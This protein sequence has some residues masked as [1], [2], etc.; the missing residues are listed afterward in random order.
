MGG[1][2]KNRSINWPLIFIL[3][4]GVLVRTQGL[5]N[6]LLDD[7]G[8]RQADTASMAYHMLGRLTA[9]PQ[10]WFPILNY[11]G[12]VPQK[13]ELEFPFLPYIIAW[14]WTL[15]GQSDLWGRIWAIVFSMLTVWGIFV[16]GQ[17]KFSSRAGLWAAGIYAFVP[18]TAYYGRVVMPEPVAQA[19]SIWALNAVV[20]W[21]EKPGRLRLAGAGLVMAFA[22]LA[23]L[24]QLMI[25]PVGIMLGFWP[26][27]GEEKRI[28]IYSLF[29]LLPPGLYYSWVHKG[30][31]SQASQFV[32]GILSGQVVEGTGLLSQKLIEN[33]LREVGL[34]VSLLA[35]AGIIRFLMV[36]INKQ[37]IIYD[38]NSVNIQKDR[39]TIYSLFLWCIISLSYVAFI[40]SRIA[41]DYY[42]VPVILPLSLLA[43]VA[44]DCIEDIPGFVLGVL[45]LFF[46]L[47]QG[48]VVNEEK[49]L[50][51]MRYLNQALWIRE[52]TP[53]ESVLILSDSPPMTF[54]YAQRVGYRLNPSKSAE[55]WQQLSTLKGDYF[56]ALPK[57]E[58]GSDFWKKVQAKYSEI[59]P[60]VYPLNNR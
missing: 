51:D 59:G 60:G 34:T 31:A 4:L 15:L 18:L 49:Y 6:P 11:D 57:T 39:R 13:V 53:K 27:K 29:S 20:F 48:T 25:F 14:T 24:P 35:A 23:K 32:S 12:P 19:F 3:L 16:F 17:K 33:I 2:I 52:N 42:L 28:M 22:I 37:P 38:K 56:I 5:M 36:I 30:A 55:A 47:I 10:V 9:I 40:C 50:W 45:V 41:L 7:Q 44:L 43:G 46:L 58:L 21:R 8:W 1:R 26:L 54:Y